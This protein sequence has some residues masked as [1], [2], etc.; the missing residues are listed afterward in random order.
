MSSKIFP[1]TGK[2]NED[3]EEQVSQMFRECREGKA[4]IAYLHGITWQPNLPSAEEIEFEADLP[5]LRR[6]QDGVVYGTR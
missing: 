2:L 3:Y 5:V 1:Y 4:L 6:L